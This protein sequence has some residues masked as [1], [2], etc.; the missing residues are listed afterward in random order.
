MPYVAEH[1][2]F[3]RNKSRYLV[4]REVVE[5]EDRRGVIISNTDRGK[6]ISILC[7]SCEAPAAWK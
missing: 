4:I 5:V 6:I 2:A 1:K 7:E 3:C